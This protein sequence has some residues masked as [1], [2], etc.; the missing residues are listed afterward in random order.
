MRPAWE[1]GIEKDSLEEEKT[2]GG[3]GSFGPSEHDAL[4]GLLNRSGFNV[5]V[6]ALIDAH[7]D[8]AYVLVYGDIDRFKR[9]TI[10][11]ALRRAIAC[12]LISA[13]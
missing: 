6:R 2:D 8:E 10:C 7:P 12:S 5:R 1:F 3:G 13:R 4:S 9:I 11:S